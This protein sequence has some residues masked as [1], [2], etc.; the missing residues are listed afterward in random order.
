MGRSNSTLSGW[1]S[2]CQA[3]PIAGRTLRP[4]CGLLPRSRRSLS[5]ICGRTHC[6][7]GNLR[8]G[9]FFT[10]RTLAGKVTDTRA[11]P[12]GHVRNRP[13]ADMSAVR[14]CGPMSIKHSAIARLAS[15][16]LMVLAALLAVAHFYGLRAEVEDGIVLHKRGGMSSRASEPFWFW[17]DITLQFTIGFLLIG[18]LGLAGYFGFRRRR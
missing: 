10:T 16:G 4:S 18:L 2:C 6:G 9:P 1:P 7:R 12:T 8:R 13:V 11:I 15:F 3:R 14:H 5:T 17:L